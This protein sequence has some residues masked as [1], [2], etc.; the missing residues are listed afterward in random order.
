ME[1]DAPKLTLLDPPDPSG[2][3][4]EPIPFLLWLAVAGGILLVTLIVFLVRRRKR[5]GPTALELR[6]A[7]YKNA[8][9]SLSTVNAQDARD[10]AVQVS[11]I[12]RRYLSLA[13]G[14]PSLYETHEEFITRHDS[15]AALSPS[16]REQCAERFARLASLK[17]G[18]DTPTDPIETITTDAFSL[19]EIL[20]HGFTK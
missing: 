18:R 10:A 7:A 17:Y 1:P 5:R 15:L 19:L 9:N 20:H 4:P 12:L 16:A 2:L 13:A 3:L 6:E 8:K 11:L 14:D